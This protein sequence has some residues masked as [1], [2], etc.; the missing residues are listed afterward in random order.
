MILAYLLLL[1]VACTVLTVRLVQL[2]SRSAVTAGI[3]T[4]IAVI[5]NPTGFTLGI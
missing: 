5:A 1:V 4:L 3:A 2:R